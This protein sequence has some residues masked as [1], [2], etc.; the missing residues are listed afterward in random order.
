MA[1]YVDD[2]RLYEGRGRL[3]GWWC[4]MIADTPEELTAMAARLG[5]RPSWR[6]APGTWKDHYDLRPSKRELAVR[7][8]AIE[9]EPREMRAVWTRRNEEAVADGRA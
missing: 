8:G 5:L 2:L 7:L 3:S 4:H 9:V 6:Q 1:V